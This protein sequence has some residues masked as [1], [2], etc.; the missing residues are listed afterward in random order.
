MEYT[1]KIRVNAN[2][3]EEAKRIG[4]LLQNFAEK[5]DKQTIDFLYKKVN[6]NTSYFKIRAA[7]LQNPIVQKKIR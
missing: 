5:T 3:T 1:I 7:K 4:Q 6:E 2:S